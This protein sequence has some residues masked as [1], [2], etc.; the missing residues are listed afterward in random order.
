MNSHASTA[1]ETEKLTAKLLEEKDGLIE[2]LRRE[3]QK[4][5]DKQFKSS[6]INKKLQAK[7]KEAEEKIASLNK[8]LETT[9]TKLTKVEQELDA[10]TEAE[11]QSRKA[12]SEVNNLSVT[13]SKELKAAKDARAALEAT[14]TT[15]QTTLDKAYKEIESLQQA[16]EQADLMAQQAK[17]QAD[18]VAQEDLEAQLE[19]RNKDIMLLTEDFQAQVADL[20]SALSRAETNAS[21]RE[22]HLKQ[23]I[24][25]AQGRLRLVEERS[26]ET[27]MS[28]TSATQPL[29]RQVAT[30][31]EAALQQQAAAEL[32][33]AN[34]REQCQQL[35]QALAQVEDREREASGTLSSTNAKLTTSQEKLASLRRELNTTKADLDA[36]NRRTQ[37]LEDQVAQVETRLEAARTDQQQAMESWHR[38]RMV[39]ERKVLEERQTLTEQYTTA[40]ADLRTH[41]QA[42]V[43]DARKHPS[44]S[45]TPSRSKTPLSPGTSNGAIA[46]LLES[47]PLAGGDGAEDVAVLRSAIESLQ[48]QKRDLEAA[49]TAMSE[50]V[51]ML[52]TKNEELVKAQEDLAALQV[53]QEELQNRYQ[54][55]LQ[56]YGE[57]AEE[58]QELQFDL[59]DIKG[60]LKSQTQQF[61]LQIDELKA[62][63][64]Q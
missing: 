8:Q 26:Q 20:R 36:A 1:E 54:H 15:L 60:V 51:V 11:R 39:L 38:E 2:E 29:L 28:V 9:Q 5:S 25:D 22:A 63:A 46:A 23:E 64:R 40:M 42:E 37:D 4:I 62:A 24:E 3:A 17:E 34:L 31:Q 18:L 16:K 49:Q 45:G 6:N 30:M 32:V 56:M 7:N 43:A 59:D 48:A 61:L 14:N 55:L 19:Q 52:V 12:A 57:K 53:A 41:H 13:Q 35:K 10:K 50:E 33:E 21:R 47:R 44:T 58:A 27:S